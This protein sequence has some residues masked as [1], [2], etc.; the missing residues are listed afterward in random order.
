MLALRAN[1]ESPEITGTHVP[2]RLRLQVHRTLPSLPL[3]R[4]LRLL[5]LSRKPLRPRCK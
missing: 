4:T 2:M 5:R 1:S 3:H